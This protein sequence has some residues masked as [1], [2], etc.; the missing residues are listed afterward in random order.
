MLTRLA[1][2]ACLLVLPVT[3]G[4]HLASASL[5]NSLD[6]LNQSLFEVARTIGLG[7]EN[8][9]Y[10]VSWGLFQVGEATLGAINVVNVGGQDAYHIVSTAKTLPFFDAFYK[11]RDQNEAWLNTTNFVSHG[12]GKYLHEGRFYRNET[13]VFDHAAGIFKATVKK[14][15]GRIVQEEG[16]MKIFAYDVLSALYWIRAQ[17]LSIG[18]EFIIDVNTRQDWPMVVKVEGVEKVRVPAGEFECFVIE[19]SLR[20]EGIFIQ[21]GKSMRV[22]LTNDPRKIPVKVAAEVF[23]GSVKAE[24][25]EIVYKE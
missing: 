16:P 6:G 22:W 10:R 25:E 15:D 21:K 3:G 23:I 11:V 12:F 4:T 19:P 13:V 17:D 2:I 18:K 8:Y 5:T 1:A 7:R 14:K 20:D 9:V 24:L